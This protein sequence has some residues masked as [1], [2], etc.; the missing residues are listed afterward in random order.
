MRPEQ[1]IIEPV[2]TEKAVGERALSRYV[3]KVNPLANKTS[4]ARAIGELFKVSVS[5]VNTSRVRPKRRVMGRSIGK[6]AQWKKAY[7][8][9]KQG[10]KIEELEA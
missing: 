10:Q 1:I 6:T 3:F 8:T 9:L 4:I 7:V 2:I 5:A